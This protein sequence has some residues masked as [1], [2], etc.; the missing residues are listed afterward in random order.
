MSDFW[1]TA[2]L[3][4]YR[5]LTWPYRA[6]QMRRLVR[7]SRAPIILLF[8]HRVADR[9]PV[10]WSLTNRQFARHVEWLSGRFDM[11]SMA[12][13]SRR[14]DAGENQRP[15]VHLTFD[16]G[17]AENCERALP[18]LIGKRIPCTYFVTLGNVKRG[19]PFAHDVKIGKSFPVNTIAQLRGLA[20]SGVEIGAHT[21]THPDLGQLHDPER[22]H[23][24]VVTA[25]DDLQQAIGRPV[26]YFAFPFGLPRNLSKPA[27]ALARRSGYRAVCSAYGGY[28][29]PGDDPFHLQRAHGDPE[30]ARIKNTATVDPRKVWMPRYEYETDEHASR[31][32]A[33]AFCSASSS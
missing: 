23:D 32:P 25:R 28:N 9:D 30:L 5:R 15:A 19:E 7:S 29:F 2:A 4:V 3:D 27:F 14:M 1:K 21:R 13:V 31:D 24:E 18:L 20:E 12:E 33:G 16:D 8:Y 6:W 10:P 17:Y 26:R 22:L 11:I